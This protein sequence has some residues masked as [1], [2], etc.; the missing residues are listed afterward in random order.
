MSDHSERQKKIMEKAKEQEEDEQ[1]L[2]EAIR[3]VIL[4]VLAEK[5]YSPEDIETD[6]KFTIRV[7]DME[8]TVSTD[9]IIRLGGKRLIAIKCSSALDTRERQI[10]SLS[11]VVDSHQIPLSVLT[12][13]IVARLMDTVSGKTLSED[14]D[15]LPSRQKALRL[16]E[17]TEFRA[18][19]PE[20]AERE[21]RILLA[22]ESISCPM[23]RS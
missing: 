20:R 21:K 3:Q 22:F 18:Y 7:G 19:P 8:E 5:G 14:M 12:D 9:F 17:D 10:V 15:S 6:R 16:L 11:R 23:D 1:Y 4:K 13:G 2:T